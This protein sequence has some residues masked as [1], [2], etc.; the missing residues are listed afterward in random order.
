MAVLDLIRELVH[1]TVEFVQEE[2]AEYFTLSM[3]ESI[4]AKANSFIDLATFESAEFESKMDKAQQES[5]YR[6]M[7]M[8]RELTRLIRDSINL[9]AN[10]FTFLFL[11]PVLCLLLIAFALPGLILETRHSQEVWAQSRWDNPNIRRLGFY[12][13][14]LTNKRTV[15]EVRIFSLGSFFLQRYRETYKAYLDGHYKL[16]SAQWKKGLF[17]GF[18]RILSESVTYCVLVLRTAFGAMTVGSFYLLSG[19]LSQITSGISNLIY[20]AS[21]IYEHCLFMSNVFEFL[22]REPAMKAPDPTWAFKAPKP[23]KTGIEF[24]NVS[25]QYPGEERFVFE[26]LSFKLSTDKTVAL[27]GENGA[28]KTTLVKL[29]ARLYDPCAGEILIDGINLKEIDIES[30]REQLS[31]IFQE[32]AAYQ[33]TAGENIGIGQVNF[34]DDENKIRSAAERGGA[35]KFIEKLPK[36]FDT[37]LGKWFGIEEDAS[38]LSGGEWQKIALSRVF[39]RVP[40]DELSSADEAIKKHINER[41]AQLLILD[42]PTAALDAKAE[43]DMYM[44]FHELTEGKMTVLISHRF[45][46][47]KIADRILLLE[48]GKICEDGTHDELMALNGSYANM[49]KLQ[50][51][52]YS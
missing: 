39:M 43:H 38:D 44:R 40:G 31:V 4:L 49:Y 6:P 5:N 48:N 29:L 20:S 47:V 1:S 13:W 15:G 51:E 42:E 50:A 12:K 34:I 52:K 23:I 22:D 2:L 14:T 27:V 25:F 32:F 7:Q 24:R 37:L 36:K 3:T 11:E 9:S 35:D 33:L 19:M 17:L 8:M 21:S 45:S 26:D 28:G 41:S 10:F 46:T 18:I 16:R 30:W